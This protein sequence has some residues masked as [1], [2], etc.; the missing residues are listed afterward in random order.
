MGC[1]FTK[2]GD[3]TVDGPERREESCRYKKK[4]KQKKKGESKTSK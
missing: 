1:T 3:M 2:R 4:M